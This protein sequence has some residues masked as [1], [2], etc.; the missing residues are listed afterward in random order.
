MNEHRA[1]ADAFIHGWR[2]I[3]FQYGVAWWNTGIDHKSY[4]V[5]DETLAGQGP[6]KLQDWYDKY[7]SYRAKSLVDMHLYVRYNIPKGAMKNVYVELGGTLITRN[8]SKDENGNPDD[9]CRFLSSLK[10]GYKF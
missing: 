5:S 10:L 3:D 9:L 8:S 1:Y 6:F 2:N 7:L 4:S